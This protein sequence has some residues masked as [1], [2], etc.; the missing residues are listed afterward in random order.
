M[1][2]L[3]NKLSSYTSDAIAHANR[4][5]FCLLTDCTPAEIEYNQVVVS[6]QERE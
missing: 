3:T 1:T 6:C 5:Y 4:S 2:N